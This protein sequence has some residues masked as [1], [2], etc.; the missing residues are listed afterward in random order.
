MVRQSPLRLPLVEYT[1]ATLAPLE[2]VGARCLAF[3]ERAVSRPHPQSGSL[4]QSSQPH[5]SVIINI[6]KII[7]NQSRSLLANGKK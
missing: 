5:R 7:H 2:Q 4:L 6:S 3:R 1:G